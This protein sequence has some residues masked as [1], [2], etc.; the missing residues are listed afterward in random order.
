M[1]YRWTH[2]LSTPRFPILLLLFSLKMG[3]NPARN[4]YMFILFCTSHFEPL[5]ESF[6]FL[7]LARVI[8]RYLSD[9][10]RMLSQSMVKHRY[11]DPF[12]SDNRHAPSTKLAFVF[13]RLFHRDYLWLN[14]KGF[15]SCSW[16]FFFLNAEDNFHIL[17]IS[18]S[19]SG[20]KK[21][22]SEYAVRN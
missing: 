15:E 5:L 20:K 16:F 21:Y 2:V 7:H 3:E 10:V 11:R 9:C 18:F 13:T 4:I 19:I 12:F 17:D 22:G 8:A 14:M 1:I 6:V